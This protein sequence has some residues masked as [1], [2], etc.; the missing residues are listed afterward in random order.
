MEVPKETR[1]SSLIFNLLSAVKEYYKTDWILLPGY[2]YIY[3]HNFKNQAIKLGN[4]YIY[5][6][7][8]SWTD[9]L[10]RI[11]RNVYL[12]AKPSSMSAFISGTFGRRSMVLSAETETRNY[13]L[14]QK[15]MT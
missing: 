2:N 11:I 15:C 14:G 7:I 10:F 4:L 6:K 12:P 1:I 8:W 3:L 13:S 9:N 5:P